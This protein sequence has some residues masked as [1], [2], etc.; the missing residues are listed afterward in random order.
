M[1]ASSS[2]PPSRCGFFTVAA[3]AVSGGARIVIQ[4]CGDAIIFF[5]V[6]KHSLSKKIIDY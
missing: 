3:A 2:A 4:G 6:N 1:G 5:F